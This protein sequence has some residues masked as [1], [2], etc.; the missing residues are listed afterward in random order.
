LVTRSVLGTSIAPMIRS[1]GDMDP[2]APD[3]LAALD[4]Q[5]AFADLSAWRK[6]RVRGADAAAWLHDLITADVASL[7][8]GRS[9]RSL[10]LT[11]TGRIR[12]DFTVARDETSLLLLQSPDQ[13]EHVGLLLQPYIL[14]SDVLLEDATTS[15]L[16][17]AVL[18]D[19]GGRVGL[20]G[21]E[22]SVLGPGID[23]ITAG[24]RPARRIEDMLVKKQ[25]TEIG[26]PTLEVR[27]TRMGSPRMGVDYEVGALPSEVGLLTAIDME[28]GCF[29]G[30]ESVA[31]VENLGHPA[32]VLRHVWTPEPVDAGTT[33]AD[34]GGDVGV[35]TSAAPGLIGGTVVIVRVP[36]TS[37]DAA[38]MAGPGIPLRAIDT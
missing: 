8:P 26:D 17:F 7:P 15:H 29:L 1:E 24:G 21:L 33:V 6:V 37:R 2:T 27:R 10:M 36:W 32:T 9:R 4:E 11:P 19:A 38:I 35:I 12:A 34:E 25:L 16:L 30:Q 23:V 20:A 22:P 31:K 5:R 14:S 13:P 3:Q 28:K 18:D